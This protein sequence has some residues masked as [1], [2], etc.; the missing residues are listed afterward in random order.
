MLGTVMFELAGVPRDTAAEAMRL[1]GS[2]LPI[3]TKF[4]VRADM[5]ME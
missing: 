2:K 5:E 4:V 1:A 3:K